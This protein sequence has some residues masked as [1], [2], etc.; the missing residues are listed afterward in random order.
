MNPIADLD[1]CN[2]V[3]KSSSYVPQLSIPMHAILKINFTTFCCRKKDT[4]AP[5]PRTQAE[6]DQDER[7]GVSDIAPFHAHNTL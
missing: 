3:K 4:N 2:V 7:Q 6:L 5:R 1:P